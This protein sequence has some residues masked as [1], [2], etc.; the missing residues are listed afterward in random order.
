MIPNASDKIAP[1][2]RLEHNKDVSQSEI[3]IPMIGLCLLITITNHATT[4]MS[5]AGNVYES[6]NSNL[7]TNANRNLC[8]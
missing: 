8:T 3:S 4:E 6:I 5:P 7:N 2:C 1:Q